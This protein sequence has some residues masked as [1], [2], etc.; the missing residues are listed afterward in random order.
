MGTI[1]EFPSNDER[2]EREYRELFNDGL[3]IPNERLRKCVQDNVTS[4]LVKYSKLPSHT[5]S[6]ELPPE[7]SSTDT[8][9]L[10]SKIQE[11]V[12]NY[13]S[14]IQQPMLLEICRLHVALCKNEQN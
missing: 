7:L 9:I 13:V 11:E 14:K 4:V 10:V 12:K 6:L 3:N 5:F 8:D 2:R 1:I